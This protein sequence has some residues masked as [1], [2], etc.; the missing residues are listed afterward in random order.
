MAG[1][2]RGAAPPWF[3]R[4]LAIHTYKKPRK[5]KQA[6]LGTQRPRVLTTIWPRNILTDHSQPYFNVRPSA[7]FDSPNIGFFST[8]AFLTYDP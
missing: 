7:S 5:E 4:S 6:P 1:G 2:S 8:P 3:I